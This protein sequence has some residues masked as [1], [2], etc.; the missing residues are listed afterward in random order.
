MQFVFQPIKKKRT[1]T[2]IYLL[3]LQNF[4]QIL[5]AQISLHL[6]NLMY[7]I[8]GYIISSLNNI[9]R[10]II[11]RQHLTILWKSKLLKYAQVE[12][13]NRQSLQH[14][15]NNYGKSISYRS[16][17]QSRIYM[18]IS[19]WVGSKHQHISNIYIYTHTH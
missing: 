11:D 1:N 18:Y 3:N 17:R 2:H 16:K 5:E 19:K 9:F 14:N 6:F 7:F 13:Y 8:N 15:F 4:K 12:I 10:F